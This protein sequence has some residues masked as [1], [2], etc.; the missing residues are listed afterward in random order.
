MTALEITQH[1]AKVW[2][3]DAA[4]ALWTDAVLLPCVAQAALEF[5]QHCRVNEISIE[6]RVGITI[7]VAIGDTSL[8]QLP[9]DIIEP[10]SLKERAQGSSDS[11]S[12]NI[13]EVQDI[14][15]NATLYQSINQWAFRNSLIY[16]NPPLTIREVRLFYIGSLTAITAT[17][18]TIDLT[19]SKSFLAV[20]AAQIAAKN[21]GQNPTKAMAM[22]SDVDEA[23]DLLI[24]GL[25]KNT[26]TSGA[27]RH[28]AYRKR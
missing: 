24:R 15:P 20:R 22:Q 28:K 17:G 16:I 5:E 27:G 26:Q 6:V 1:A 12:N 4:Q 2:L 14:D 7:N 13:S 18:S 21:L 8:S 10:I 3:N 25:V 23:K 19:S 11:W 9:V